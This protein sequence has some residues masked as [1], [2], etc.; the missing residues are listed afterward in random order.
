MKFFATFISILTA[1]FCFANTWYISP[2]GSDAIGN[3]SAGNPWKTL[4]RAT[5]AVTKAG[6]V[7]HVLAGLY[8]ETV[9]SNLAVG[10]SIEGE[11]VQ[12]VITS[13][14]SLEFGS[15]IQAVSP[16]GTNGSQ[17]ISNI[18]LDG[19]KRT[20]SWGIEIRGRSNFAI[21]NCTIVDF[22]DTGIFWGGRTDNLGEA[23]QIYATGNSFYNNN[24][25][26][27]AK[28]DGFGRGCLSIGGQDGMLIY[29]NTITQAG[30]SKGT[31]GWPIKGCN[32]G[33]LKGCKIY[34]NKITKQAYDGTSWDF[35]IELFDVSGLEIYGNTIIGS[36][37]LNRQNKGDYPY[38]VYIHDNTIGPLTLQSKME[39]GII[40]EF[41]TED[42]IITRNVLRN[43]GTA[44]FFTCRSLSKITNVYI[45]N[46][47][48]NNI[49]VADG[50]H[51]GF[52][53]RMVSDGSNNYYVN[54]LVI[55]S[56]QFI[57][58]STEKP[59]W[60][61]G[62]MDAGSA[63]N[64]FI[65]HNTLSNFSA[66][67]ITANPGY[68]VDTMLVQNN[69]LSGNGNDNKAAFTSGAPQHYFF[70]VNKAENGKVFT[71]ANLKQNVIRPFYYNLKNTSFLEYIA[72]I[73]GILSVWFS[74]KENI[75]VYPIGLISTVIYI[76]LSFDAN[77]YGEAS[78][79]FYY[80]IM[81]I[82][83]WIIWSKRD[84][85][86]HRVLRVTGSSTKEWIAQVAFFIVVFTACYFSLV[87]LKKHFSPAAIPLADSF[88][89][90]TAFTGMWLMTKKKVESWY[91]WIATNI[92]SIPLYF[93]KHFVLTS[94]YYGILLIMAIMGLKEWQKRKSRRRKRISE[95]EN[96]EQLQPDSY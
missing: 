85:K 80:T 14:I 70:N 1:S 74:R 61:I 67:C 13:T 76:F 78:V 88:A 47:T 62:V 94:V 40:L 51:Q 37:D 21:Y 96:L 81:S 24:V 75:Y 33:F 39:N 41:N 82:W 30:R 63:N 52:A 7:I 53:V 28:Y 55:D 56:N 20:T 68:V 29:D 3:G 36:V 43:L 77:L 72:V 83:G 90:A 57:G 71:L 27:C 34:N 26:N 86:Q 58:N 16:E 79:N 59:Y 87:Y 18:K 48:C 66:G 95:T 31:N 69:I 38:S 23:P 46:N 64:I 5:S 91:W 84:K 8:T 54:N 17:H 11:G 10:V 4:S 60:G 89:T 35:A 2:N 49:G 12:S 25:S 42:A 73:A 32:D 93:S 19:N 45:T 15:L 44:V 50:S 92:I 22:D 6:D 65:R 9:K